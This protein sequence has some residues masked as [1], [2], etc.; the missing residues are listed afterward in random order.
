[1]R[2]NREHGMAVLLISHNLHV[3][4]KLCNRVLVMKRGKLV[5]D[6][7]VEEIFRDPQHEYT[8]QLIA[9]IPTRER[10]LI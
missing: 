4:R 2:L 10:K 5:E 9:A 6:R 7:P 1:K 8:K 3:V